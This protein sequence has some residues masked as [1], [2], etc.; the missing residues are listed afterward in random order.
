MARARAAGAARVPHLFA[1]LHSYLESQIAAGLVPGAAFVA[2]R[3]RGA[4]HGAALGRRALLPRVEP[5]TEH[6]I[7]DLA[8]LTKPM[9][10]AALAVECASAGSL[11]LDDPLERH[12]EETR[13]TEAGSV[14]L[15]MLLT[16][17]GGFPPM[18]PIDDYRG[19][20]PRLY[21][22]IAREPL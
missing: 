1:P 22:A 10:T 8:S 13:G 14:R 16:H 21:A 15:S 20:K 2:G 19:G 5:M 7:F 11:D 4:V 18:N 12:L 9:A 6:T 17:T 3:G